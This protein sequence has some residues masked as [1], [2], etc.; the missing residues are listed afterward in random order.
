[1]GLG[2]T[3]L[4]PKMDHKEHE[5]GIFLDLSLAAFDM[6]NHKILFAKLYHY[7]IHGLG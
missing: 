6:V 7:G 2:K 3:I 4:L 1:M 5:V